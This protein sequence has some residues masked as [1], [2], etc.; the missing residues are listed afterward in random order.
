M[1]NIDDMYKYM[2]H[3]NESTIKLFEKILEIKI[4]TVKYIGSEH[5]NT[6][7]EYDFSLFKF[8][9]MYDNDKKMEIYLKMIRGGKIK[10]SIFCFWSLLY[11]EY[12][13]DNNL[14]KEN[15][16]VIIKQK[17]TNENDSKIILTFDQSL[18]YCAEINLVELKKFAMSDKNLER[19]VNDLEI[20]SE[21]ILFIG[22]K[23]KINL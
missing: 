18:D 9:V 13:K 6:I 14:L 12:L 3:N 16:K 21:D 1:K 7:T 4:Q 19:L 10:E 17:R 8:E 5:F 20:K 23:N 11:E 22:R 2:L 15:K